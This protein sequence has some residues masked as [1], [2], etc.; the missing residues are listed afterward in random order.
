MSPRRWPL[1]VSALAISLLVT[2]CSG[3][4][5]GE[6][7]VREDRAIQEGLDQAWQAL[8]HSQDLLGYVRDYCDVRDQAALKSYQ[9]LRL[10][11]PSLPPPK[12]AC[13]LLNG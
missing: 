5:T 1:T 12:N 8:K 10:W 6:I 9:S 4:H 2:G 3:V 7:L 13:T 11:N